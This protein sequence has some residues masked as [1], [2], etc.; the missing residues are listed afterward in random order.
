MTKSL[1]LMSFETLFNRLSTEDQLTFL[2]EHPINTDI[3]VTY[4]Q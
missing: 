4:L 1:T 3:L 2:R